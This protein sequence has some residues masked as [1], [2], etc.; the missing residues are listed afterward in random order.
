MKRPHC[1]SK[2]GTATSPSSK[3]PPPPL[4]ASTFECLS[5]PLNSR[6]E[7]G[8]LPRVLRR[9]DIGRRDACA[10][11]ARGPVADV[12]RDAGTPSRAFRR[13]SSVRRHFRSSWAP[14]GACEHLLRAVWWCSS[15]LPVRWDNGTTSDDV[16]QVNRLPPS[17]VC[18]HRSDV[19]LALACG[20]R[21]D[22]LCPYNR[23]NCITI[24]V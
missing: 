3:G 8:T 21:E 16:W 13:P 7:R 4:L 19:S 9:V 17:I 5:D 6:N 2:L 20:T 22:P 24:S 23:V 12:R 11:G 1:A 18:R 10:P 14:V 15:R